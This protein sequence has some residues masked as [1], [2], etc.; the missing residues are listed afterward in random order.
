MVRLA[1]VFVLVL[2]LAVPC[3]ADQAEDIAAIR[4][5]LAAWRADVERGVL[6]SLAWAVFAFGWAV[7][8]GIWSMARR[9]AGGVV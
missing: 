2:L 8:A 1:V 6:V 9:E 4:A 7:G 3:M 5:E